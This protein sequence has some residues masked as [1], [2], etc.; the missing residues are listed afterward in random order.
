MR[1]RIHKAVFLE[2]LTMTVLVQRLSTFTEHTV[3]TTVVELLELVHT[4]TSCSIT[5]SKVDTSL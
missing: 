4:L 1:L 2:K 5:I 3:T